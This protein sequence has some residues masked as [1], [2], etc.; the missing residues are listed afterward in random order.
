[1]TAAASIRRTRDATLRYFRHLCVI[2]VSARRRTISG[3]MRCP[4]MIT[5]TALSPRALEAVIEGRITKEDVH[6]AFER[7]EGLLEAERE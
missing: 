3:P 7:L 2:C 4:G 1:M 6:E 5:Y